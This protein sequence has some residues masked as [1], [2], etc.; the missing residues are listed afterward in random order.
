MSMI[1][2]AS[3]NIHKCVGTDRRR[4]PQRTLNVLA[5]INADIVALQEADLRF[6]ERAGILDLDELHKQ[7]GLVPV[8]IANS[9]RNHGWH[10][11]VVLVREASVHHTHQIDLPGVEPRGALVVDLEAK[12]LQLR[13]IATHFGLLRRSRAKQVEAVLHSAQTAEGRTVLLMGDLN[14]WRIGKRSGIA[15]LEPIF[16]NFKFFA[17]SYPSRYPVLALDRILCTPRQS[18]RNIQV[19]STP[20]SREASD[21]L[22]I[23]AE[24]AIA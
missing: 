18:L 21:H 2:V 5:E 6:G 9:K 23:T 17:P 10:G 14:E 19:H 24:I 1:R 7:L 12:S 11:N 22:P 15:G 4:D 20:L 13:V 16:G 3:Y 8:P